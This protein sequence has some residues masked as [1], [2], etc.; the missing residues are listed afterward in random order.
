LVATSFFVSL[1]VVL[2]ACGWAR[3]YSGCLRFLVLALH[4]DIIVFLASWCLL[5][6]SLSIVTLIT[7]PCTPGYRARER[8]VHGKSG[9]LQSIVT[10]IVLVFPRHGSHYL[11]T[12]EPKWVVCATKKRG[13]ERKE[14]AVKQL[15][16][17]EA[18]ARNRADPATQADTKHIRRRRRPTRTEPSR[19][20]EKQQPPTAQLRA[21]KAPTGHQHRHQS[22]NNNKSQ[23]GGRKRVV[24]DRRGRQSRG[25]QAPKWS[26]KAE[27]S[28]TCAPH[29]GAYLRRGRCGAAAGRGRMG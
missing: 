11:E 9:C 15:R 1:R 7:D 8:K 26:S 3:C 27:S 13:G 14:V 10:H 12:A 2:V 19:N 28:T 29:C 20:R 6:A 4:L 16:N 18:H 17:Q 21:S 24:E 23:E 22:V 25:I 5:S